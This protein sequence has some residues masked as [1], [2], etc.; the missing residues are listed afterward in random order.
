MTPLFFIP[1]LLLRHVGMG[2]RVEGA[3]EGAVGAVEVAEKMT[4]G[5]LAIKVQGTIPGR[6]DAFY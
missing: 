1:V 6:S 4:E 2:W 3:E 5:G